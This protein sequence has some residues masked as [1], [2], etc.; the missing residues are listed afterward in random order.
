ML[1]LRGDG[2][3]P[4][5]SKNLLTVHEHTMSFSLH[6]NVISTDLIEINTSSGD[7]PL[8]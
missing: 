1:E 5:R 4:L 6:D 3:T 7:G 2:E 8:F